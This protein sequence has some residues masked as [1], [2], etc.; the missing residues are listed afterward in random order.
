[1]VHHLGFSRK[2]VMEMP[3]FERRTHLELLGNE[4]E[5]KKEAM[6]EART[7]SKSGNRSKTVSGE[8]LKNKMKNGEIN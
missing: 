1:M 4:I 6:E 5:R 8:A 3:T 2:D 7:H